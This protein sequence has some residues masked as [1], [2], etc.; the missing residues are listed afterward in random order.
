M[1]TNF[2]YVE[3]YVD[4][5]DD[6][7][8]E[9]IL[10]LFNETKF[11]SIDSNSW[12]TH[13]LAFLNA[14]YSHSVHGYDSKSNIHSLILMLPHP[15]KD[16]LLFQDFFSE[17]GYAVK[18]ID[19]VDKLF[20]YMV[21]KDSPKEFLTYAKNLLEEPNLIKIRII[22]G[23][24][25]LTCLTKVSKSNECIK[26]FMAKDLLRVIRNSYPHVNYFLDI[27]PPTDEFFNHLNIDID[28][29]STNRIMT[30]LLGVYTSIMTK[31]E[32]TDIDF[33]LTV[34]ID[35]GFLH[36][37]RLTR[38]KLIYLLERIAQIY[39]VYFLDVTELFFPAKMPSEKE[40][41]EEMDEDLKKLLQ[42]TKVKRFEWQKMER[43]DMCEF[44]Q[45]YMANTSKERSWE[46]AR[47]I[48]DKYFNQFS[49]RH[50]DSKTLIVADTV[51]LVDPTIWDLKELENFAIYR[52]AED[53]Q[54]ALEYD[55][56]LRLLKKKLI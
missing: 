11:K 40:P 42:A 53:K 38:M 35:A 43:M 54:V 26:K 56:M 44:Y 21:F 23:M 51:A 31:P 16:Q 15:Y 33:S 49:L 22:L 6:W 19:N 17:G 30:F 47:L 14:S 36:E 50:V 18:S 4:S 25:A 46:W 12:R 9:T 48:S 1:S 7:T 10:Q 2:E 24:M 55:A 41:C 8:D 27:P 37:T 3:S 5:S 13:I 29:I 28:D 45:K 52:K 39:R 20:E 32:I 34:V